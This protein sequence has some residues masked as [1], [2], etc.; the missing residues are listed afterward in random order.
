MPILKREFSRRRNNLMAQMEPDSIAIIASA[1]SL[2]RN[3]DVEFPFR[4]DSDFYYLSG[5]AEPNSVLVLSPKREHGEFILFCEERDPEMELWNGYR[6]G[7]DGACKR[8][9]ADDA[10]PIADIDDILPG[11]I[12]GRERVYYAMGR[13]F[14]FDQRLMG[15]V[16]SIRKKA[17]AGAHPPGE[18]VDLDHILHDM[19]LVK[20]AAELKVM[21]EAA[22]I[23]VKAHKRAMRVCKPGMYE[24]QLQAELEHEFMHGGSPWPAYG[25]IVGG[26]DNG[27]ILHYTANKEKLKA[28]DL[29]LIDAGSELDFYASD[30][31][32]TF[33]VSGKFSPEQ[34]AIYEIVL[35]SQLEAIKAIR[36]GAH[37]NTPHDVTVRVITE[38]LKDLGF[39]RGDVDE[40]IEQEAHK[41]FYMHRAGHWLGMDVHDVGD[42]KVGDEWRMLEPGMVLT[43]E[44]GIYISANNTDV[45]K[46]WRGI[47]IRIEDD[48]V[49][50]KTKAKVLTCALPKKVND[51]EKLMRGKRAR[52]KK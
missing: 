38:G 10:F 29:V 36:P 28:G 50:T 18:F 51:I 40:L 17:R 25:S 23:S 27:C 13:N 33:P 3:R 39:L 26:G 32:R 4:Q 24:Y 12:E 20:S 21:Q 11:L 46:K 49:V 19:R 2:I 8:Y 37:W 43:V 52:A 9:G 22:D 42:Y 16:N 47:G 41:P 31:T 14:E 5:F 44:P 1:S 48:V 35:T 7:Q 15:W 6:A 30:I 34:K 45:A